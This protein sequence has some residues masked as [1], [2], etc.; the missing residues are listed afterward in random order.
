MK[1][2]KI[3]VTQQ[4]IAIARGVLCAPSRASISS[5]ALE[6]ALHRETRHVPQRTT[7]VTDVVHFG[8]F[9]F[10]VPPSLARFMVWPDP[11]ELVLW[12]D[13]PLPI[14]AVELNKPEPDPLP[15]VAVGWPVF[16]KERV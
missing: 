13:Y 1:P 3:T 14:T 11:C 12:T 16:S 9:R 15:I 5:L 4:D 10:S 2:I 6:S 8:R 7:I